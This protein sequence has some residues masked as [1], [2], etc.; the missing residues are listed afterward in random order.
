MLPDGFRGAA[1]DLKTLREARAE[2][3][4]PHLDGRT[5]TVGP[6]AYDDLRDRAGLT[7]KEVQEAI[8]DLIRDGRATV[9]IERSRI[10]VR[11]RPA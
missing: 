5:L 6:S 11:G 10:V 3:L 4:A 7:R 8:D 2:L 9:H 1:S